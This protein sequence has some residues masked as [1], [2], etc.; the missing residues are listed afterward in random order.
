M[1][2]RSVDDI[3]IRVERIGKL[4][5]IGSPSSGSTLRDALGRFLSNPLRVLRKPTAN[6]T[7]IIWAL[8]DICFEVKRGEVLGVIGSNGAGKSTLLK[9][10]SRITQPTEGRIE[11]TGRAGSLL[12]VGTGFHPELTGRENIYHN[13]AILGMKRAEIAQK[14]DQIVQFAELER[15]IDTPVKHYSSGMY[16]RLAFSVAAHLQPDILIVDE[17]LA[18]GDVRFQ[19]KCLGRMEEVAEQGRTVLFVSHNMSA[20]KSLCSRA[21]FL[22]EGRLKAEGDVNKIVDLYLKVEE[23]PKA[24]GTIPEVAPRFGTREALLRRVTLRDTRGQSIQSVLLGQKFRISCIF[25]VRRRIEDAVV[26]IGISDSDGQRVVTISN[27]DEGRPQMQI[28]PGLRE[29]T[30]EIDVTLLPRDYWIDVSIHH[31]T[32]TTIDWIERAFPFTAVNNSEN[33]SDYYRWGQVRGFVRPRSCW[34][35]PR[36]I[37]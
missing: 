4:Y 14:F 31:I 20:V 28:D 9:I 35:N 8:K 25:E 22:E 1:R 29:I 21:I 2:E 6:G 15:F 7:G 34:E 26:E 33:A 18:V 12:E 11:L 27:I 17:V 10:L 32:G 24:D 3:V 36:M 37:E 19:K 5:S 30:A 16:A 13:G 23:R